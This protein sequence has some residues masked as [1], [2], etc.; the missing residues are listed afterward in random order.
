M[1]E[2]AA[3]PEWLS[4]LTAFQTVGERLSLTDLKVGD[5]LKVTTARSTYFF[6]IT[7]PR[8][9]LAEM[10]KQGPSLAPIPVQIMGCTLGLS[11]TID[12]R[13]LFCGG[14][15]EYTTESGARTHTSSTIKELASHRK[16]RA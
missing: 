13:S 16:A 4:K 2:A 3:P 14:S 10:W 8:Q 9:R 15:L 12:P 5:L 7:E 1:P 6:R 11:S